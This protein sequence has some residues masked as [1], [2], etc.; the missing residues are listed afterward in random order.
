MSPA[1]SAGVLIVFAKAPRPGAVKTRLTPSLSPEAAAGLY[2]CMLADVLET[3][4]AACAA[5]GLEAWLAVH[6]EEACA[7]LARVAPPAF[8]LVGQR[9]PDLAARM[10][11]AVRSAA[12]AGQRRILLRG[13]DSPELAPEVLGAALAALDRVPLVLCPGL[14]GGYDLVG[15]RAPHDALFELPMSTTSVLADTLA[16]AERAKLGVELLA[17]GSDLDTP[18]DLVRLQRS[19]DPALRAR[20]RRTLEWL[21][22]THP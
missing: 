6:P 1:R 7:E 2:A 21:G 22:A 17:P 12:A 3:S 18:A 19:A 14:D 16:A 11:R 10:Q 15:L 4:A 20:C 5:L 8:R 9:G 13:S